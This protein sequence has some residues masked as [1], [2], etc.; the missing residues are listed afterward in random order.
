MRP[1]FKPYPGLTIFTVISLFILIGLGNWQSDRLEWKTNLLAEV[2]LAATAEPF[3]SI[4]EVT[5]ALNN[6][7]PVDFRRINAQGQVLARQTPFYVYTRQKK[8]L[9]WRPFIAVKSVGQT[10]FAAITPVPDTEKLSYSVDDIAGQD[11]S[12][13]GY[14]RLARGRVRGEAESTPS[15]NRW[16]S[17]N[18][19]PD[20]NNWSDG[21]MGGAETRFYIDTVPQK[22]FAEL[23][24]KR[25][26]IRNNHLDY[27]LTWYG[28]ALC[29]FIVYLILHVRAGRLRFR[30]KAIG[31]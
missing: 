30:Q 24:I 20:T 25:P 3:T 10:V 15:Q 1:F 31:E 17:F 14:V 6:G 18:P 5:Q 29:L 7:Q 4:S 26:D 9:S 11:L 19:I 16:F 2:E 13:S 21:V 22:T 28:L 12:L 27:M 23:P 8:Q